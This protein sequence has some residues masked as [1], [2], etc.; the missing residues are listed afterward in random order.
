MKCSECGHCI[1][2]DDG[3]SNYTV[4][5]TTVICSKGLNPNGDFDRWYGE[6]KRDDYAEQCPEYLE[7]EPVRLDVECEYIPYKGHNIPENWEPYSNGIIPL[8]IIMEKSGSI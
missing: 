7:A 8:Q 2:R 3:Y 1:L 6:D 4:E 5:G